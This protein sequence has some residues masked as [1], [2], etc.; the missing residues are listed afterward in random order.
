MYYGYMGKILFVDLTS[1]ETRVEM[2]R[3]ELA[4]RWLGGSG[5]AAHLVTTMVPVSADPLGEEN[6][7]VLA[8]GPLTGTPVPGSGRHTVA[9]KSPLT[10][11]WGES[12]VGGSW[13]KA[14]KTSGFD[15]LVVTGRARTPVYLTIQDG[16]V[17]IRPADALWGLDTYET[18]EVLKESADQH[19]EVLSIG[20]AGERMSPIAGLFTDGEDGRAAARCGLGAV[21]GAKHM[22]AIVV[23]GS[24]KPELAQARELI[25][26]IRERVPDIKEQAGGMSRL[27]TAG[28]VVPC[29]MLGDLPV[30]NWTEG[31]WEEGAAKIGGARLSETYLTGNYHCPACPIGCGRRVEVAEDAYHA[32][33]AGPEY[34]TLALLG[35]ACLVDDLAAI[36]HANELCN[37]YGIDTIDAG[38]LAA[39]AM[40]A[41]EKGLISAADTGGVAYNWGDPRAL[42]ALVEGM[43]TGKGFGAM[44]SGG[45]PALKKRFGVR[46]DEMYMAVKGLSFPGHDPRCYNSLAVGY[47]TNNRGACHLESFS[48]VFERAVSMPEI[49][50]ATPVNRF[51]VV[52]K[53]ELTAKSQNLMAALDSL[54]VCKF[55]LFGGVKLTD[56][57]GWLTLAV[58]V[59]WTAT[60]LLTVGERIFNQRRL[61]NV[62]CGVS[63]RDD[64]LPKRI[65]TQKRG[66][67]G[68][69]DNLPPL[70][71]ML[72]E[73]YAF[74]GW[75]EAGRPKPAKLAELG[76]SSL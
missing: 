25:R 20:P 48:H 47:A 7:L 61:F 33:G 53:G 17:E 52:G 41:W 58:G 13:G 69:A 43:G 70:G 24:S 51:D 60:D 44:L 34:E 12:S 30:K 65:L 56:L 49:G 8:T 46:A 55:L 54:S 1:G 37:R 63:R 22:K 62:A 36:C 31:S 15:A 66:S 4:R 21:A 74:R 11:L 40:E 71:A 35:A 29:E 72:D 23:G 45:P 50:V 27:G 68:A 76:L 26:Q 42:I 10:N 67:G 9:A 6:V 75:D 57:A 64:T 3:P 16:L 39:F 5:L 28:L 38:N 14:L 32:K 73:Y 18:A 2:L 59:K 19:G